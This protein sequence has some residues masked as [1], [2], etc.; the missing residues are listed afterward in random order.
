MKNQRFFINE[1]IRFANIVPAQAT[2]VAES[3]QAERK[4][5]LLVWLD[6]LERME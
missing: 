5:W 2:K 1:F 6:Y 3:S 4:A